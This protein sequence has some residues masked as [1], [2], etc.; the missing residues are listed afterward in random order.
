MHIEVSYFLGGINGA[1]RNFPRHQN[2]LPNVMDGLWEKEKS[3][4]N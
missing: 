2:H 3:P 1:K 4:R